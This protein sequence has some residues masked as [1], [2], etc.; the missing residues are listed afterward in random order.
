MARVEDLAKVI[1]EFVRERSDSGRRAQAAVGGLLDAAY[2]PER[3]RVGSIHEPE[4][5]VPGDVAVECLDLTLGGSAYDRVLEVRDKPVPPHA[6]L[7]MVEKVAES[8]VPKAILVAIA[9]N[10]V[11]LDVVDLRTQA[12]DR[13]VWLTVYTRRSELVRTILLGAEG[14]EGELIDS[15]V[16]SIRGRLIGLEAPGDSVESWDARTV[17]GA[18][19]EE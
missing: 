6:V 5:K 17:R 1:E 19:K 9:R 15:A 14:T 7:M 2:G 3:V 10:Q 18:D 16:G 11:Q 8:K 4:R 12:A 13:G